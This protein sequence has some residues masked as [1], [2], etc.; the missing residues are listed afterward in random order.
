MKTI[1]EPYKIKVVEPI[2]LTTPEQ[3]EWALH[4][5][6]FNLFQV[7]AE[8]VMIDLLTDSGTAAMVSLANLRAVRE[9]CDR[10][11]IPLFLDACRFAE[12]AAPIQRREPGQAG[13]S[14]RAIAREM[15]DLDDGATI[16][17]KKGGD[18]LEF[19]VPIGVKA[20]SYL[21]LRNR[22][23]RLARRSLRI[24]L[25]PAHV[26]I[27]VTSP[28]ASRID[29]LVDGPSCLLTGAG[30]IDGVLGVLD[31][32]ID[33]FP[34]FLGGAFGLA[35]GEE[36]NRTDEERRGTQGRDQPILHEKRP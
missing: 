20:L 1:I 23:S 22:M 33:I 15:F 10:H 6:H 28:R 2:K 30:W 34:R 18:G 13:R 16:G 14:A 35:T 8:V 27:N 12:N 4:Q 31:A 21:K 29:G 17:A 9:L 24:N 19:L 5:A 26:S 25:A 11:G 7:P 3:R 36:H 32:L